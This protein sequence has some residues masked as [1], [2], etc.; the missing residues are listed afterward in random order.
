MRGVCTF[1]ISFC[2]ECVNFMCLC[3]M[4]QRSVHMYLYVIYE[5]C[6]DMS[7]YLAVVCT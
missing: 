5:E 3:P 7:V 2:E 6:A 4:Y 1:S